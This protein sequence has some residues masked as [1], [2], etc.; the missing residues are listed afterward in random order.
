MKEFL[1]EIAR[2]WW[3]EV[4]NKLTDPL[5]EQSIEGLRK[6]LKEEYNFDSEVIEYIVESAV[7]TPTNFHLGGNRESGMQVGSND[8][9][10]SAHLHSDEDDDLDGA[11]EYD[12]PIAEEED[13]DEKEDSGNEDGTDEEDDK[14]ETIKHIQKG[15]LTQF[16]K[17]KLKEN[18]L[19]EIGMLIS[20]ASIFNDKYGMG[21]KV[22]WGKSG[23]NGFASNLEDGAPMMVMPA[24][25]VGKTDKS[26]KVGTDGSKEVYLKD[27]K[28]NVYHCMGSASKIGGWF[29]HYKDNNTF[30]L[31]TDGKE[32]AALLGVYMNAEKY[33]K[34]FNALKGTP[35]AGDKLPSLVTKFK[36]DVAATLTGQD[37]ISN[38]LVSKLSKAALPNVIQVCAI[39]AGMDKFCQTKG[40]K[41]YS[42]IHKSIENYYTAEMKNPYTKTEGGKKNTADCII[43][44]GNPGSFL[45]NMESEKISY[46]SNGLCRLASGEEFFQVSLK[47]AADNAQLG[48][49][50]SDF[51]SAFGMLSNNDLFNMYLHENSQILL[52]EG[53]K[54]L[55]NKGLEFVKSVGKKIV[56]KIYQIGNRFQSY[57]KENLK[58]LQ[59]N[60]KKAEKNVDDFIM[61]LKVD[62]K[63]LNESQLLL[64]KKGKLSLD[65]KI[66]A[67]AKDANAM[68]LVYSNVQSEF[69]KV[70]SKSAKPGITAV[71]AST[72]P[73]TK[74]YTPDLVRKLMANTKAYYCINQMLGGVS[75]QKKDLETLFTDML[76]LEKEMYFGRT[77]LP[78][79]KVFGLKPD[80]SGTAWSFLKTGKEFVEERVSAFTD[81]PEHVLIIDSSQ[82]DKKGIHGGATKGYMNITCLMLSH[83]DSKTQTPKYNMVAMRTNS[84]LGASFVIEGSKVVDINYIKDNTLN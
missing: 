3:I 12:E 55:F 42:I 37:W 66:E 5:S 62:K 22:M 59:K 15:A 70:L 21:H 48:K 84:T 67:I 1:N 2:L 6:I 74:K 32:T 81:M 65:D 13:K 24:E 79:V 30:D 78:L 33:L 69:Q 51:A 68:N 63:Y 75:A 4:G 27:K 47:Q 61:K 8:T 77:S 53:L 20:E 18:L 17:D 25:K 16:E 11:I 35:D 73:V 64:E 7:K 36:N 71:G 23:E 49:I 9:A 19:I 83:L 60:Q 31:D 46:E 38:V 40:I 39:A 26:F 44:K 14:K 54:D 29:N 43:L 58:G 82:Q 52:D 34:Q 72:F 45:K 76:A 10:V 50:T 57:F 28:G 56:D 80:G 41:G